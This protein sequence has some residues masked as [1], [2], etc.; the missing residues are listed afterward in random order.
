MDKEVYNVGVF[1]GKTELVKEIARDIY[2][3]SVGKPLVADQ[4]SFNYLIQTTYKDKTIF[5]NLDNNFAVHLHVIASGKI[6]F[7]LK[8]I[9]NYLIVHQWDRL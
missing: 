5:T 4:T 2:L 7:D 8:T 1:G 6:K 3:L 9:D